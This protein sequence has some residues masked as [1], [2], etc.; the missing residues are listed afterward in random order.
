MTKLFIHDIKMTRRNLRDTN[1]SGGDIVYKEYFGSKHL[2]SLHSVCKTGLPKL[3]TQQS[4]PSYSHSALLF[5]SSQT[6]SPLYFSIPHAGSLGGLGS[7]SK[8]LHSLHSI[9]ETGLPKLLAQQSPPSYSHSAL[10][11]S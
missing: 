6:P 8:H 7:G 10:L 3:L 11:F 1:H 4:P 5:S 9:F 2:H